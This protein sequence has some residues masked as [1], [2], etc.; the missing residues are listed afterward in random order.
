M[1]RF[2]RLSALAAAALLALPA[3]PVAADGTAS[4]WTDGAGVGASAETEQEAP[5]RTIIR[6]TTQK[7]RCT[8][9]GMSPTDAETADHM[10][11]NGMGP[12]RGEGPG[13][14][15]W[16]TCVEPD[17][18]AW[19]GVVWSPQRTDPET[20][21]RQALQYTALP[22]PAIGMSPPPSRGAVVNLPQWLWIDPGIWAPTN[23][24]ATIDGV[25]VTTSANPERVV[26]DMG[27]G[28]QVV[29]AGPGTPYDPDRPEAE[30]RSDCTYTYGTSSA[31]QPAGAY[32]VTATVEWRVTW[33]ALGAAGG[34]DL[35]VVRRSASQPLPVAEI[36][37]L[38]RP[39]R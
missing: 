3:A 33:T 13:R 36:Q 32:V 15:L 1:H 14:W 29:C 11:K 30:Q 20:V 16:K 6:R 17:G 35:G 8:Y 7:P 22:D 34:G 21:A 4:G 39:A 25:T 19:A 9:A 27:N 23:A 18:N 26:F 10:A 5:E 2:L 24:T 12:E 37:S 38:N 31:G 28:D